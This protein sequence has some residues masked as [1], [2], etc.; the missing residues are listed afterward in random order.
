VSSVAL[1][2]YQIQIRGELA[3]GILTEVLSEMQHAAATVEPARTTLSITLADQAALLGVLDRLH[4]LGLQVSELRRLPME[5]A[6][7]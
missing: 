4:G 7:V 2:S 5:G 3:D 1:W 6:A